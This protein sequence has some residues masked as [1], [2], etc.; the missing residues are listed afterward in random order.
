VRFRYFFELFGVPNP[1]R[2]VSPRNLLLSPTLDLERA[3]SD[4]PLCARLALSRPCSK[5]SFL[6]SD[7]LAVRQYTSFLLS[8]PTVVEN[9][10]VV[11]DALDDTSRSFWCRRRLNALVCVL[12]V[13]SRC[14][15]DC[16]IFLSLLKSRCTL[17]L[18]ETTTVQV[19]LRHASGLLEFPSFLLVGETFRC[20]VPLESYTHSSVKPP[21][22]SCG[23]YY[24][25]G[26][27]L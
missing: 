26:V 4:P 10:N 14:R 5:T 27:L 6:V 1:R 2:R 25:A 11:L 16:C 19:A 24:G 8:L 22:S 21:P 18:G 12:G 23:S 15:S 9:P 7:F 3:P 17:E 13:S 20:S